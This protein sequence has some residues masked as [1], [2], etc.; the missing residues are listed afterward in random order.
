MKSIWLAVLLA[1]TSL[2]PAGVLAQ[3][4]AAATAPSPSNIAADLKKHS[5][6]PIPPMVDGQPVDARAPEKADDKPLF[7]GQTRAPYHASGVGYAVTVLPIKLT[8]GGS[9]GILPDGKILVAE[10]AG[11]LRTLDPQG[12]VSDPISGLPKVKSVRGGGLIE[13]VVDPKFAKTRRLY[14]TYDV[15]QGGDADGV[16]VGRATLSPDGKSLTDVTEIFRV[17]PAMTAKQGNGDKGGRIIVDAKGNLFVGLGARPIQPNN[18]LL[19]QTLDNHIGKI[20]H[21]TPD[22]KPVRGNPF[23]GKA[24]AKPEIWTSGH[25]NPTGLAFDAKGQLWEI[26]MG[27]RGGDELNKIT[28]G[29]NYGWPVIAHG[30]D[31]DLKPLMGEGLTAKKGLEQP[32]Y[33]WDPVIAPSGMAFYNGKLFPKW[34]GSFLIGALRGERLDRVTIKGDKVVSEEP[35]LT[36]VRA[37]IRDVRVGPDGAIYLLTDDDAYLLKVTPK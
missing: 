8:R 35:L 29:K 20:I 37:R 24:G 26:E 33:Y 1:G 27:P 3:T 18:H 28:P 21:I 9:I 36:E 23:I 5:H 17:S 34:K 4:T 32:R 15:D 13:V 16:A 19:A 22:G 30:L 25:R 31:D 14:M 11:I 10:R 2:A 12:V 7:A 6:D